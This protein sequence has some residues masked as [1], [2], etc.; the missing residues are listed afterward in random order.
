MPIQKV[1]REEVVVASLKLFRNRGYHKTTMADIAAACGLLKGSM[2]HYFPSKEDLML[3]VL[4]YLRAYYKENVFA[5]AYQE[6]LEALDRLQRLGQ[7]SQEVFI[8]GEG[9]CLMGNIAMETIEVVPEFHPAIKGFFDD[10]VEALS[11]IFESKYSKK[12]ALFFAKE[13]VCAIEGAAMMMRIYKD[14]E[15]V[16]TAHDMI[17]KKYTSSTK[18]ALIQQTEQ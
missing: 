16:R 15:F 3:A 6:E 5:I 2:Y 13:A 9:A 14:P 1:N 10:W 11:H 12:A 17:L 4:D 18:E 8:R 7:L